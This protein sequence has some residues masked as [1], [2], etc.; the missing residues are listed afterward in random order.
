[1]LVRMFCSLKWLVITC[2]L[3]AVN[4]VVLGPVEGQEAGNVFLPAPRTLRQH[5]TRAERAL[6]EE[7]YGDAV[8]HLG[9]LLSDSR[10]AAAELLNGEPQDYFIGTF[11]TMG[12][13]TSL[14][15]EAQRLLGSMP[16]RARELYELQFGGDARASLD[17]AVHEADLERLYEVVRKY[18]HTEAGYEAMVLLG[19]LHLDHGRPLA[20]AL[21]FRRVIDAPAAAKK[22]DPELSVL[23][24]ACWLY[25]RRPDEARQT[26]K[27]LRQRFPRARLNIGDTETDTLPAA[28]DEL[29][30]LQRYF[31]T[32]PISDDTEPDEWRLFRGNVSRT[33]QHSGGSTLANFRWQV[34]TA[35]DPADARLIREISSGYLNQS[36]AALPGLHPLAV[37]D[38]ILMRTPKNILAIDFESGKR[39]W[40]Y[41]WWDLSFP[42]ASVS[43]NRR[44]H[45]NTAIEQRKEQLMQRLWYDA[46]YGHMSSDGDAV[47]LLHDLRYAKFGRSTARF[48]PGPGRGR[49][50][51]PNWPQS[52]NELV[53]LDLNRQ[54][55]LLWRVGG[56]SGWEEPKLARAF[57]LGA[58]LP[59]MEQL[60]VLAELNGEI[61]LVALDNQTGRQKWSQ[62]LA[63]VDTYTILR[64]RTRRLAGAT[65]SYGDGVLVCPTSAGAVVAVDLSTRTLLWGNQYEPIPARTRFGIPPSY[66]RRS[67][68]AGDRWVDSSVTVAGGAVLLTP[69]ES[70]KLY[71][72]D[73]LTGE[74]KWPPLHR[75][76]DLAAMQ[77]LAG[78]HDQNAILVGKH[79]IVA[80]AL[81]DGKLAWQAPIE[82]D[83]QRGEMPSGRG[84]QSG[85]YYYLPT[86]TAQL[87][88]LDLEK[89][90]VVSREK[91]EAVLG[92]LICYKDE[93]IS[94]GPDRLATYYQI[95]PLRQRV[96]QR[97]ADAPNDAWALAR[98]GE[99]LIHD[100]DPRGAL[101]ALQR[102]YQLSPDNAAVRALLVQTFLT[103]LREDFAG[104]RNIARQL[105][106]LIDRP[107]QRIEY[108]RL[109]AVGLHAISPS[110]EAAHAYL[111]LA[112]L[113]RAESQRVEAS[114]PRQVAI[115]DD[116]TTR[117]DR[118]L[119][120]RMSELFASANDEVRRELSIVIS[121]RLKR[122]L[123]GS[124]EELAQFLDFYG[125]HPLANTARVELA[126][127]YLRKEHYLEASALYSE[128]TVRAGPAQ[129][130]AATAGLANQLADANQH[131]QAAEYYR[132]LQQHWPDVVCRDG[133]TGTQ[134]YQSALEQAPL[135]S[136]LTAG[137][138][139]PFGRVE[140]SEAAGASDRS[141]RRVVPI[142]V[143]A[144]TGVG[145]RDLS[146]TYDTLGASTIVVRNGRGERKLQLPLMD[147]RV[148][149][150]TDRGMSYASVF[151]NLLLVVL[152]DHVLAIDLNR[153]RGNDEEAVL[154]REPFA[155][156]VPDISLRGNRKGD[157]RTNNPFDPVHTNTYFVKDSTGQP[158]GALGPATSS[159][160]CYLK[161]RTLVC[162]DPV[163]GQLLWQRKNLERGSTIFGD[164]QHIFV[165][166]HASQEA[167]VLNAIDG[168]LIGRRNIPDWD[169]RWTT[170]GRYALGWQ[171]LE[172]GNRL[173]L[174]DVWNETDIWSEDFASGSR[175]CLVTTSQ[176]AVLQ[177]D[178]RFIIRSLVD[179]RI[180]VDDQ[181][182]AEPKLSAIHV[183]PSQRR[184]LL[185]TD[186]AAPTNPVYKAVSG[187]LP[188]PL[189]QGR[190]YA[191]DPGSGRQQWQ[192]PAVIEDYGL[193]LGQPND[194]PTLWFIRQATNRQRRSATT[195]VTSVLCL[196][197]RDGRILLS[198]DEVPTK[199]NSY[200]IRP[201]RAQQSV[202][203]VL[204]GRTLRIKFTAEPTPPEPPAQTGIASSRGTLAEG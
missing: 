121:D 113:S 174:Y 188:A 69:V 197:R 187:G 106:Q 186:R 59:L 97:L 156:T 116:L 17:A 38:V 73:L 154:W 45:R 109:M 135:R 35:T 184:Y 76:G 192:T 148:Y 24:A 89:G 51:N 22:Y 54:G 92:N 30:W 21:C 164:E 168:R 67:A 105:E 204:P 123:G 52:H 198:Q 170:S 162:V 95:E 203:L 40:E 1:M 6:V 60:F 124:L 42:T 140:K 18:F 32:G 68:N 20:A 133:Q 46:P 5:L 183:L 100:G 33:A 181:L 50:P 31:A 3:V 80:V 28:S 81:A 166:A 58:P 11:G 136:A 125:F 191:F 117:L 7:Q 158:V 143:I 126:Q 146:V 180:I 150:L 195:D 4:G 175:G 64:N 139:W 159:G 130:A 62:Q 83:E 149:R 94:Q 44:G 169:H 8:L 122:A 147:A 193:P 163:S 85:R 61:R 102:A 63:H 14:K 160:L 157:W 185:V 98:Q 2:C 16:S 75:T 155:Q 171:E 134:L 173:F 49:Q 178:G 131:E 107:T 115:D 118:W 199:T 87:L 88:K 202:Q 91:T 103:A 189:I 39:I 110:L 141:F 57:F 201:D 19:R 48:F 104:H 145:P 23:S 79:K 71:C 55:A 26:L 99:L 194:L 65:P 152:G 10:L 190:I 90:E 151:G 25:A 108:L 78:V 84:F 77:Y 82:L 56:E 96:T 172:R 43:G 196:D 176:V 36:V 34:P 129:L 144:Y 66:Q 74:P 70:N 179:D 119:R 93:M 127:W 132:R 41:P 9:A 15:A 27:L 86:T 29:A 120:G 182:V 167:L 137:G 111:E 37:N 12:A 13:R 142:P 153:G 138:D 161:S 114:Q 200:R 112:E 53:A 101:T 72:L 47:Y 128:M 165:V 177:P